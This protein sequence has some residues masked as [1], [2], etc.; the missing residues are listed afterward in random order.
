M[1]RK[2]LIRYTYLLLRCPL[3]IAASTTLNKF[4]QKYP[5]YGE[6]GSN[7]LTSTRGANY[8][9]CRLNITEYNQTTDGRVAMR[10]CY[11]GMIG[12]YR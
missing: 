1:K 3:L 5:Y 4:R 7:E 9:N 10:K 12:I 8:N 2:S 6:V 11:N